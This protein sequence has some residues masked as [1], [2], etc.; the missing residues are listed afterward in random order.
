MKKLA[1]FL[2]VAAASQLGATD[3]GQVIRDPGFDLWCGEEPCTWKLVRGDIRRVGTWNKGDSGIELVGDDAAIEQ[4]TPVNSRD[5]HCIRFSMITNVEETAEVS[6]DVDLE[7][8]GTVEKHEIVATS[9]WKPVSFLI[10]ISG[11]YDGIRFELNKRGPG[12]AVL[13]QIAAETSNDCAGLP[14]ISA[15][16]RPNGAACSDP[17]ECASATCIASPTGAPDA[18]LFGTSCTGCDPAVA[19][20]CTSGESCG[21]GDPLSP[22]LAVPIKCVAN[23][24]R[25]LGEQCIGDAECASAKCSHIGSLGVCSACTTATDC[26]GQSCGPSWVANEDTCFGPITCLPRPEPPICAEDEAPVVKAGCTTGE[27]IKK[28]A[29][30]FGFPIPGPNV[31]QPGAH[32]GVTGA[33]CGTNAD[34]AS[35]SCSGPPRKQCDDGRSCASPANCP[36]QGGLVP[37]PCTTVGVEGGTCD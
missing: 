4:F 1:L 34:C 13:A 10:S 27:C 36:V 30:H 8:D 32:A 22:V 15:G 24:S 29:C 19:G 5:G 21:V 6:L 11:L 20:T 25:A 26:G 37:G 7:G 31:C 9:H 33:G 14:Q 35:N 2:C 23:G 28:S 3:C 17:A 16:P 18:S 12:E